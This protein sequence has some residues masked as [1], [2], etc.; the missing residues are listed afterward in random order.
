AARLQSVCSVAVILAAWEATA[1]AG[2]APPLF[3]PALT[4]IAAKFAELVADGSLAADLAVSLFRA[5]GGLALATAFGVGIGPA[6]ARVVALPWLCDP[7]IALAFPSPKIAFL[8][9]FILWFG[10][11][12]L[13]K[14]LLVAFACFFPIAIATYG[15]ASSVNR[16]IIWSALAMG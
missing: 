3:L 11:G 16:F 1:R 12:S 6:M 8:P 15:A 7:L 9:V 5:F 10:I 2:L 14:V 13:A 4:T